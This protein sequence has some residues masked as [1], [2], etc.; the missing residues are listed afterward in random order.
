MIDGILERA[1]SQSGHILRILVAAEGHNE[2]LASS[3]KAQRPHEP[4]CMHCLPQT[5]TAGCK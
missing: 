4:L 2:S 3:K 1:Q 5:L